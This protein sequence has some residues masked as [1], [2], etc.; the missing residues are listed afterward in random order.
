M[1]FSGTFCIKRAGKI[2]RVKD[3]RDGEL[4]SKS[5]NM[6]RLEDERTE[7][8]KKGKTME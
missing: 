8:N 2:K 7:M 6:L 3:K 5:R 1:R 4:V